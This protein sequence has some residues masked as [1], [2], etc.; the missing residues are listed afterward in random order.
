MVENS[1]KR[2]RLKKSIFTASMFI[3]VIVSVNYFSAIWFT[4]FD[5]T[6]E[7]RFT[8]SPATRAILASLD[9]P[10]TI[11]V[12]LDGEMPAAFKKLKTAGAEML[13]EFAAYSHGNLTVEFI[14]PVGSD[15]AHKNDVMV[16]ELPA[17]HCLFLLCKIR[18]S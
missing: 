10:I 9:K 16:D 5:F 2:A 11:K 6:S 8:L 18:I 15:D 17:G 1:T 14:N 4:R 7:K 3:L 13:D 12:Y